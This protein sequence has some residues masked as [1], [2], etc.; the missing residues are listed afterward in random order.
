MV[1]P[2]LIVAF[3]VLTFGA[4]SPSGNWGNAAFAAFNALLAAYAIRAYIGVRNSIVDVLLGMV[5]WLYVPPRTRKTIES[6]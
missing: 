1:A 2:Y 5:N 4:T 6:P 3:S